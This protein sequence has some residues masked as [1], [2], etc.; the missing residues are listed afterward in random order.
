MTVIQFKQNKDVQE[1][2]NSAKDFA[3]MSKLKCGW[4]HIPADLYEKDSW[5]TDCGE[6]LW[7]DIEKL[8]DFKMKFCPF[9]GRRLKRIEQLR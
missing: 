2:L 7:I 6:L 3:P 8:T 9:C 5:L 4:E 1:A